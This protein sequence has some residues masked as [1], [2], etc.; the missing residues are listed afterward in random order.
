MNETP[1]TT[2]VIDRLSAPAPALVVGTLAWVIATAV[3]LLS[4]D[5]WS[6][7][8]PICYAGIGVGFLGYSLFWLQRRA[9]RRGSRGAQQGDGL[10]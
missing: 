10:L 8:L 5:R 4:G 1:N 6:G 3:V 2:T 9:A 7:A